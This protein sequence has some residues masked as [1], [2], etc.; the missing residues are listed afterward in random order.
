V[1]VSSVVQDPIGWLGASGYRCVCMMD[2]KCVEFPV[3]FAAFVKILTPF[4]F[5]YVC[6]PVLFE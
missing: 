3:I 6:V 5:V 4:V 2:A 1:Y